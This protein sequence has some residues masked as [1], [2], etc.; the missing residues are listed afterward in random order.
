MSTGAAA[1][2]P[3][4]AVIMLPP[5]Y[6]QACEFRQ[7]GFGA[8]LARRAPRRTEAFFAD[9]AFA[10]V[11]EGSVFGRVRRQYVLPA[12]ERGMQVWLG[13]ISLG[14]YVALGCAARNCGGLAGLCLLAPYLGSHI[15]TGEVARAGGLSQWREADSR[16]TDD[17]R[18]IWSFLQG[19]PP[20]RLFLGL[21]REDRF[22]SRHRLLAAAL[23]AADVRMVPGGHDW[24]AWHLLW[25][26]FL[27]DCLART[28]P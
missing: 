27:D 1:P 7:Q 17:E 28:Q 8:A 6:A 5:A 16:A 23:P 2:E 3:R 14:A 4:R 10:E 24:P 12:M 9:F 13:G 21:G 19:G 26:N 11:A 20:M 18:R 22:L 15:I 25:E